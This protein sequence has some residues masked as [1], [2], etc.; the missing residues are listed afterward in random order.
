MMYEGTGK[1]VTREDKAS[2]RGYAVG[3]GGLV[4]FV[5]SAAPRNRF[6]EHAVRDEVKMFPKQ[7]LRELIANALVRQD[8]SASGASVMVKMYADRVEISNP[9]LPPIKVERFIDESRSRNERLADLMRRLGLCGQRAAV[10]TRSSVRQRSISCRRPISVW[11]NF[12][13]RRCSSRIRSSLR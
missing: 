9:G 12:G 10:W 11:V 6:I 13:R 8:F 4:E 2:G 5:H 3:F 7:A 1:L